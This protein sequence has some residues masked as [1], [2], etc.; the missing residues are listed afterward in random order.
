[1]PNDT[2]S[3]ADAPAKSS[4]PDDSTGTGRTAVFSALVVLAAW[5]ALHPWV[6]NIHDAKLYA[7]QAMLHQQ[8]ETF[9]NDLFFA[10]GSQDAYTLFGPVLARAAGWFGLQPAQIGLGILGQALW[11]GSAVFLLRRL[12]QGPAIWWAWLLLATLPGFY[13]DATLR[14]GEAFLTPRLFVEAITFFALGLLLRGRPVSGLGVMALA[15]PLHPL[16]ALAGAVVAVLY[17]V[18]G[19]RRWLWPVAG[20]AALSLALAAVGVEPWSRLLQ[21][22]DADWLEIVRQR[23]DM[24]FVSAWDS[25]DWNRIVLA[26]AVLVTAAVIAS[27][28]TRRLCLATL[29]AAGLALVLSFI[30]GDVLRSVLIIQLQPWRVLWFAQ[31]LAVAVVPLAVRHYAVASRAGRLILALLAAAWL[32]GGLPV[33]GLVP[34]QCLLALLL[35]AANARRSTLQL[36]VATYCLALTLAFVAALAGIVFYSHVALLTLEPLQSD[37]SM[38]VPFGIYGNPLT[39]VVVVAVAGLLLHCWRRRPVPAAAGVAIAFVAAIAFWDQR[40]IWDRTDAVDPSVALLKAHIPGDATVF[41]ELGATMTWFVLGRSSYVSVEQG[42]GALF[43][44]DTAT[45][46]QR[47]VEIVSSLGFEPASF[48]SAK[49][50]A[51]R[52]GDRDIDKAALTATCRAGDAPD[53]VILSSAVDGA[54]LAHARWDIA[55]YVFK[56]GVQRFSDHYL[57]DCRA[58]REH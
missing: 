57:Y 15:M 39:S 54:Y 49:D 13:G 32:S 45:A 28:T 51:Y 12:A 50:R 42:A 23:N 38:S 6:G 37:A 19:D 16:M 33:A 48:L 47:R 55:T 41:W 25:N 10:F 14:Y 7:L 58:L 20:A 43:S 44:R 8:P 31:F 4:E 52:P 24:V 53:F 46:L 35:V 3:A 17:L 18:L 29:L 30:G 27:S 21:P 34:V 11:L 1:V 5:I 2:L 9:G 22:M 36:S 26:C 56:R 40:P